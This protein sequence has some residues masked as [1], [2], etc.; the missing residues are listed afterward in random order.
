MINLFSLQHKIRIVKN[1]TEYLENVS[2]ELIEQ[3]FS[4]LAD[5]STKKYKVILKLLNP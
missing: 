3:E 2:F 1:Q 4:K 5:R